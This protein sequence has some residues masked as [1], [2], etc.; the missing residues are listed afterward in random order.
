MSHI[1]RA[2]MPGV[3][4]IEILIATTNGARR[5]APSS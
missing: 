5:V 1:M 3:I 4:K 2:V